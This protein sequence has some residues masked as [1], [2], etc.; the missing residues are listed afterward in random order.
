MSKI[1]YLFLEK[2]KEGEREGEKQ[3][4]VV[5]SCTPPTGDLALNPGLC[6]D[7]ESNRGPF[8]LQAHAQSTEL[9]NN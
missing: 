7:W 9:L 2:G 8:G 6:R 1:F 5:A 3:Q 4:C